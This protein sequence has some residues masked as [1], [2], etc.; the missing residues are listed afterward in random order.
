MQDS[1]GT[2]SGEG[3][4]FFL[5]SGEQGSGNKASIADVHTCLITDDRTRVARLKEELTYFL[6]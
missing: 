3:S 1:P 5:L 4:A 2:I 6:V